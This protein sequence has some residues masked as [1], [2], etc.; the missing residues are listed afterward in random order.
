M[1]VAPS[2]PDV[3]VVVVASTDSAGLAA[4]LSSVLGQSLRNLEC[5]LV[6]PAST[7]LRRLP[8]DARLRHITVPDDAQPSRLRNAGADAATSAHVCFIDPGDN[9]DQHAMRNLVVT[10]ER[11]GAEIVA[12]RRLRRF[13]NGRRRSVL[14]PLY[15]ETATYA[16]LDEQPDL[17]ADRDVGGKLYHLDFLHRTQLRFAE[18]LTHAD[19]LFAAEAL[20]LA[21]GIAITPIVTSVTP[22]RPRSAIDPDDSARNGDLADV[23]AV[24]REIDA[25][26]RAQGR[27]ALNRAK[28]VGFIEDELQTLL[29]RLPSSSPSADAEFLGLIADYLATVDADAFS[30]VEPIFRV[31]HFLVDQRDVSGVTSVVDYTARN[32]KLST[33]LHVDGDRVFWSARGLDAP[34]GREALDVTGLGVQHLPLHRLHLESSVI[35][36]DTSGRR[37]TIEG[38]TRN[39]LDRIPAEGFA[40]ALRFTPGGSRRQVLVPV[41]TAEHRGDHVWWRASV[42]VAETIKPKLI[43]ERGWSVGVQ[44]QVGAD[45]SVGPLTVLARQVEGRRVRLRARMQLLL[46][47]ELRANVTPNRNLGLQMAPGRPLARALAAMIG[48]IGGT[49]PGRQLVTW[50]SRTARRTTRTA[51]SGAVKSQVYRHLLVRLPLRRR[52]IVFESHIGRSYSDNPRYIYEEIRRR[53][54]PFD[55]IWSFAGNEAQYPTDVH[56]VRRGTWGYYYA[57]ARAAYWVDNQGFPSGVTK[58]ARTTYLQTWHGTALK[59]M[60]EDTPGFRRMSAEAQARHRRGVAR[61]DRFLVRSEHD[62]DT[63]VRAFGVKGEVLRYGYPR[64]DPLTTCR[65]PDERARIRADLG[66]PVDATLVLYAPTFR[67]TYR[68]GRQAFELRVDIDTFRAELPKTLL[69]VR[70]HYLDRPILPP[71]AHSVARDVSNLPDITPLMVVADVLVTDYSSVMFDFAVTGRPMIFFTYDYDDYVSS[72]RGV[73]FDLAEKAPGPLVHTG[74]ALIKALRDVDEWAPT[75]ADKYKEFADTFCE[76]DHGDAARRSVDHVFLGKADTGPATR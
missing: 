48:W 70:T 28:A 16:D 17:L 25:R 38:R 57:L 4:T 67:E 45:T 21:S 76:Y 63:L 47:D 6:T 22:G 14:G 58:P 44:V 18:D 60:G 11:S 31:Q 36:L 13:P 37:M 41:D 42:D 5:L 66:L 54:L 29:A 9:L 32:H 43:D 53:E 7:R 49:T 15:S 34:G 69:M 51:R 35:E 12:G 33:D 68:T 26:L 39:Q 1:T 62:M 65:D 73:Y 3:S 59:R 40:I 75:Y 64:N 74:D 61:W 55:C 30:A 20:L 56:L 24:H 52:Q 2:L 10:A 72:E 23:L 27:T 8:A 19:Q 71:T 46:G 50:F